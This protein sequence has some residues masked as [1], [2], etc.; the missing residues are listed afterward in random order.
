MAVPSKVVDL[1]SMAFG[2]IP[3]IRSD[4]PLS[5]FGF[6]PSDAVVLTSLARS[7]SLPPLDELP[8]SDSAFAGITTVGDLSTALGSGE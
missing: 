6:Q 5:S 2:D 1:L 4:T 8:L 7:Q 3:D